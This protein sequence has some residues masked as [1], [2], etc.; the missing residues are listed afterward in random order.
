VA[1][2]TVL[3]RKV[4]NGDTNGDGTVDAKDV[5]VL[6]RYLAGWSVDIQLDAADLNGDGEVNAKDVTVLRRK[7]AS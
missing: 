2:I 4:A 3:E 1:K 6:R 5:T 7:L